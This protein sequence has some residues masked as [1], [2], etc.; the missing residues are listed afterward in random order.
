MREID[1]EV[2]EKAGSAESEVRLRDESVFAET[3]ELLE[4]LVLLD[5]RV[6]AEARDVLVDGEL[7]DDNVPK[8]AARGVVVK[9][10]SEVQSR[11]LYILAEGL[12]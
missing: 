7:L 6:V 11:R 9:P 10:S 5:D 8:V 2:D 4:D 3:T 1:G 12:I